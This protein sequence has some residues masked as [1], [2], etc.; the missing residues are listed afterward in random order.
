MGVQGARLGR[1]FEPQNANS[2]Q[3]FSR[4]KELIASTLTLTI[5]V[6]DLK[7]LSS[8]SRDAEVSRI[9]IEEARY[10]FN[11]ADGPL[12]RLVLLQLGEEDHILIFT[13]H[14][15]VC[16]GWSVNVFFSEL[17]SLYGSHF[18]GHPV[19]IPN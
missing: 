19:S 13:T 10:S 11:L 5:P 14:Q 8:F 1:S 2:L 15:I 6:L 18:N 9:I 3:P 12:L 7:N 16:D 4:K 17:E